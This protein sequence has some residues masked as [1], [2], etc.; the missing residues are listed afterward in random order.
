MS[1]NNLSKGSDN[2]GGGWQNHKN[3]GSSASNYKE[4][5]DDYGE[6]NTDFIENE[7]DYRE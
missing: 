4:D 3:W 1:D 7:D 6:Q 5:E 2:I